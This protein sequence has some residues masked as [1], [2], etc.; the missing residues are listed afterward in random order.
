VLVSDSAPVT[1]SY[2]GGAAATFTVSLD[3]PS[4]T[5][6]TVA[7]TATGATAAAGS[8]FTA[9]TGTL[10]FNPGETAKAVTVPV[11]A[12]A[13]IEG[14]ET[15]T[16]NIS[17][18]E[19][20]NAAVG[21]D[22]GAA[23]I[24]N[25]AVTTLALSNGV[26]ASYIG[27]GGKRV[28]Y[29]LK[30]PGTGNVV[31][32]EDA[33]GQLASVDLSGTTAASSLTITGASTVGDVIVN[34]ALKSLTGKS[35]DLAGT[36][37]VA[38]TLGK[39][40]AHSAGGGHTIMVGGGGVLSVV[41]GSVSNESL[42]SASPIKTL[43]VGSWADTDATPD[44]ITAPSIAAL[45]SLGDFGSDVTTDSLGK[46][47][48]GGALVGAIIRSNGAIAS[49]KA[50]SSSGSTVFAGVR[51]DLAALPA[52]TSDFANAA[53]SIGKLS[54]G[55]KAGAFANTLIA[56]PSIGKVVLGAVT[57]G[58]GGNVFGVAADSLQGILTGN[59]LRLANLTDPSSS[60]ADGDFAVRIL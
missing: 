21:D 51:G 11:L 36:V 45:A 6:V 19:G 28:F 40:L 9:T 24:H 31:L 15:F 25:Q 8:D 16:L 34:G 56:A 46:V 10:L 13:S 42:A 38:G 35:A 43:R 39:L 2:R 53:A 50:G 32:T 14:D 47:T 52:A 18:Q 60:T 58:N 33:G 23:V 57:T 54:I 3:Q 4:A 44:T 5:P 26:R 27:A 20:A 1:E 49:L 7:Y 17:V 59:G 41:L 22:A 48:V 37:N 29:T 55:G 30:G 12:D